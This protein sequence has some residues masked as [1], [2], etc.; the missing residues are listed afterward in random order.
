VTA[1]NSENLFMAPSNRGYLS[2]DWIS[3]I[4]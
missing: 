1:A 3:V 2:R 4:S